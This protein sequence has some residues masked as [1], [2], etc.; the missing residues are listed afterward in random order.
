MS[1]YFVTGNPTS[2]ASAA[3][4]ELLQGL[5]TS[6]GGFRVKRLKIGQSTTEAL[7]GIVWQ[8]NK[9]IGGF[10]PGSGG[11]A[12]TPAKQLTGMGA[13]LSTWL[14]LNSVKI[15]GGTAI[16]QANFT[17]QDVVGDDE[18]PLPDGLVTIGP[19]EAL[20]ILLVTALGASTNLT[21]TLTIEELFA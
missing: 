10:T 2:I 18:V 17:M 4:T 15:T 9:Y 8:I 12:R 19:S 11:S 13:A 7:T 6:T 1:I 21:Y 14:E 3:N 20:Q 16:A 5:A